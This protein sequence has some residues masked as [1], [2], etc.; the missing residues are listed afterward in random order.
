MRAEL[1]V[2][3]A[4]VNQGYEAIQR[5]KERDRQ[6]ARAHAEDYGVPVRV[7]DIVKAI[8]AAVGVWAALVLVIVMG[9]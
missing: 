1:Q 2:P 7:F 8:A 9:G 4:W 6:I 3:P 5:E